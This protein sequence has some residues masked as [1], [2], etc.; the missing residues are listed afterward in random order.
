MKRVASIADAVIEHAKLDLIAEG[1]SERSGSGGGGANA[2]L[3]GAS[4]AGAYNRSL[5]S[6]LDLN[7]VSGL[8]LSCSTNQNVAIICRNTD[9]TRY[10]TGA[11]SLSANHV[12]SYKRRRRRLH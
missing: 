3:L 7:S 10:T 1:E 4:S 11:V 12:A 5:S 6:M 8:N 2:A 9:C